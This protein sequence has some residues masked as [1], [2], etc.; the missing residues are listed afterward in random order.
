MW[1]AG[2]KSRLEEVCHDIDHFLDPSSASDCHLSSLGPSGP[3]DST[4]ETKET[5]TLSKGQEALEIQR[6]S[7][8]NERLE[9]NSWKIV[10]M[11]SRQ[12]SNQSC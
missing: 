8:R 9:T 6:L 2:A 10:S 5:K 12:D 3:S 11:N 7:R 1:E 4:K